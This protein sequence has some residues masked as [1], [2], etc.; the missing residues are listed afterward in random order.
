MASIRKT[1]RFDGLFDPNAVITP[2][3]DTKHYLEIFPNNI[4]DGQT[5]IHRM[6][7]NRDYVF[8]TNQIIQNNAEKLII[9]KSGTIERHFQIQSSYED[10][11]AASKNGILFKGASFLDTMTKINTVVMDKTGTVTKGV[12]KI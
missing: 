7:H 3:L 12:F 5:R 4:A 9:G 2:P 6:G 10:L 1:T 8:T 11:V